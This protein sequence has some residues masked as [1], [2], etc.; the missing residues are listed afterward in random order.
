MVKLWKKPTMVMQTMNE[1]DQYIKANAGTCFLCF[2][3]TI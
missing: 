1:L 3:R 2:T